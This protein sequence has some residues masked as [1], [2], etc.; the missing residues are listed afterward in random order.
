MN[1]SIGYVI[2]IVLGLIGSISGTLA[3]INGRREIKLKETDLITKSAIALLEPYKLRIG[4]LE[5]EIETLRKEVIE[6]NQKLLCYEAYKTKA[7]LYDD[8]MKGKA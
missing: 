3:F 4:E 2:S 7:A 5:T 1:E 8:F 6:L